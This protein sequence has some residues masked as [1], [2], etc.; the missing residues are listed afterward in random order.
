MRK[1]ECDIDL[2]AGLSRVQSKLI[3]LEARVAALEASNTPGGLG[4][5]PDN[6]PGGDPVPQ[7]RALVDREHQVLAEERADGCIVE[8]L[9]DVLELLAALASM[10]RPEPLARI[11][12][13]AEGQVGDGWKADPGRVPHGHWGIAWLLVP[14]SHEPP[15]WVVVADR[16]A[17]WLRDLTDGAA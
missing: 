13:V 8:P 14:L 3:A 1:R 4:D 17:A 5:A 12:A 16:S 9:P 11:I 2:Y 6:T 15:D 7:W 10:V